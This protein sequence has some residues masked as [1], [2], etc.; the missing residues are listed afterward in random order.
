ML[1]RFNCKNYRSLRDEQELS[2]AATSL[3]EDRH[4]VR[5]SKALETGVLCVA[6]LYG[7]NASGKT[8]VLRALDFMSDVVRF[9]HRKWDPNG[10]LPIEP[11]LLDDSSHDS[12][13]SFAVDLL[14][15]DVRYEYGFS[16]TSA[17]IVEEWAYA[18]PK[19]KKQLWFLR[20]SQ[21]S[22]PFKF[23]KHLAGENRAIEALTRKNSLFLSAAAQNNHE[24]LTTLY[25]WFSTA[26]RVIDTKRGFIAYHTLHACRDDESKRAQIAT[27]ITS[28]D[29]GICS[30]DVVDEKID[31]E[32]RST[33]AKLNEIFSKGKGSADNTANQVAIPESIPA[34]QLRH[35]SATKPEGIVFSPDQES[36]GTTAW[37]TL[38]GPVVTA[39][40]TGG[41]ILVD[42]L[43]A[44]LHPILAAEL[45]HTFNDR[46]RNPLGAQLIFNTHDTNLLESGGLRRDQVWFVEKDTDGAS[47]LYPLTDFKPR[48]FENLERGYLQGRYGAIPY[49]NSSAGPI[50]R[51]SESLSEEPEPDPMHQE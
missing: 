49:L 2:L 31:E 34:I 23:G 42:E 1:I 36:A 21:Q 28:A 47:H 29:L 48:R 30:L 17:E 3:K 27:L 33:M 46:K 16:L 50:L 11:F 15:G 14:I 20:D 4:S 32:M 25:S 26:L 43:D 51:S 8:N 22:P 7:P 5:E 19:G 41:T 45:I 37:L 13:S 18:Y 35:R 40:Q 39:L 12:P 38:L 9:S 10:K 24:Q 44:S 6:A